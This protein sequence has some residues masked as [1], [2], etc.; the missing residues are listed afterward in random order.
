MNFAQEFF[1]QFGERFAN[2]TLNSVVVNKKYGTLTITFLYPSTDKELLAEEKAEISDWIKNFLNCE[3]LFVKVKFMRVFVEEKLI[4][5]AI[6]DFF[7]Q[8]YKLASTYLHEDSFKI[9]TTPIDVKVQIEVSS[10]L[11]EMFK[12]NNIAAELAKQLSNAFLVNF[13]VDTKQND[14]LIDEVEIDDVQITARYRLTKRFDVQVIKDIIGKDILPKP[15]HL[16]NVNS[17]RSAVI[18]AGYIKNLVRRDYVVKKGKDVGKTKTYFTFELYEGKSKLEC[19]HFCSQANLKNMDALEECMFVLCQGDYKPNQSGKLQLMVQKMA[20]ASEVEQQQALPQETAGGH[21]VD[22]EKLTAL[23]QDSMFGLQEK[24]NKKISG[25]TIV[26]FDIETTGLNQETDQITE[27]GAV[28]IENGNIIEKFSTFVKPT[29][30]IPFEVTRLTG[31]TNEMV[32]DA[33]PVES[34]IKDFYDFTRGCV[35]SGHNVIN[36]DMHFIKR[37]GAKLG[38]EFDNQLIDTMNEARVARLGIS[39]FNLASVL[40]ALGLK[41]EGAHRAWN[42]AYATAQA[43]LKMNEI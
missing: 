19:I 40:K 12:Q 11:N 18:V 42:D 20:L 9:D 28:K 34:V 31:I 21:V 7:A 30:D 25:R 14:N 24:Y 35:I 22:I 8:K 2:L 16:A 23:E 39:H 15:E 1:R 13:V 36:F 33:P 26:V 3:K 43:L 5:K 10:R 41:N 32:A 37:E 4:L 17:S 27:L 29:I 6:K 38:L